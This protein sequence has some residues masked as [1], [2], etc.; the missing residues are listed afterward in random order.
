[1]N[2]RGFIGGILTVCAAP[3]IVRASS[4]MPLV[5]GQSDEDYIR[6]CMR[7]GVPVNPGHYVVGN[8]ITFRPH[9][10]LI[11][12]DSSVLFTGTGCL[13]LVNEPTACMTMDG[14]YVDFPKQRL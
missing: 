9:D 2:R 11:L 4:L 3:A 6:R 5:T 12:R 7:L 1:M 10:N 14:V 13:F 8:Q